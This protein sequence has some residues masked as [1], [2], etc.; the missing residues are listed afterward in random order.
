MPRFSDPERRTPT[1]I[2]DGFACGEKS[3]D[4]WIEQH[5]LGVGAAGSARAYVVTDSEQKRVL[6]YHALA[7][8][9]IAREDATARAK[10]GMSR[11]PIGAVLIARLAVDESVQGKG[12]GAFLL[13]DAM[14]RAL[15]VSE[16]VGIRLLLVH[17]LSDQ[18]ARFYERFG[19][20]A[21]PI[22]PM[23]LQLIVKDARA[24]LEAT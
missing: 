8:A 5:A 11:H 2:V 19:F 24:S 21:S 12:I 9:S 14:Q 4:I 10:K 13:R 17:A 1:H 23:S 7:V 16:E 15:E 6:G 20:E 3:L 18:A 22:S